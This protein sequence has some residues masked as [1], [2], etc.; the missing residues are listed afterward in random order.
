MIVD[1]ILQE[2]GDRVL[3]IAKLKPDKEL[4]QILLE[5]S[6]LPGLDHK[7][8]LKRYEKEFNEYEHYIVLLSDNN[9]TK[10]EIVSKK[11]DMYGK[12]VDYIRK[13]SLKIWL[14][15]LF[16]EDLKRIS[17]DS[18]FVLLEWIA[19]GEC[20]YDKGLYEVLK[21]V[22][23][24]KNIVLNM[25][26]EVTV[27]YVLAGSHAKG[28]AVESSDIDVYIIIDD[29]T[30]R[31]ITTPEIKVHMTNIMLDTALR[32]MLLT[33]TQKHIHPLVYT[34]TEFWLALAECNPIIITLLRDGIAL[35]DRG[36]FVV[37]KRLLIKGMF[38]PSKEAAESYLN[39]ATETLEEIKDKLKMMFMNELSL[40]FITAAQAVIMDAG[41]MPYLA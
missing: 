9:M 3:F 32:A 23:T 35:F 10:E 34:L 4:A 15:I 25:L 13:N 11:A 16:M 30:A 38:K 17:M 24:H 27:A 26:G 36:V 8:I 12:L 40:V 7:A 18:R 31:Y 41:L 22:N 14:H 37:W 21:V 6:V 29:T 33:G 28:T 19:D 1:Q 2:G 5:Y 39:I 20:L